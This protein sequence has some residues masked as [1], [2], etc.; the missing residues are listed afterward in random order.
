MMMSVVSM[1]HKTSSMIKLRP[2]QVEAVDALRDSLRA[3]NKRVILSAPCSMGKTHIAAFIAINAVKKNPNVKVAFFCDRLTLVGQTISAFEEINADYSVLQADDPRYDP[4]KNI[5]IVSTAT[6]IRR[7]HFRYD[8]A[9]IDEA[10]QMYKGLLDQMRQWDQVT[11]IG[12][13]ATPFSRGMGS[14]GLWQDLIVTTTPRDLIAS[15]WLC[16]ADY[17][18]GRS[19]DVSG[20]K[21]KKSNTGNS[22]Y[23]QEELGRRMDEDQTLAGDIVANYVKHSDNLTKRAVCFAPSIAY[24]KNLVRRFNEELGQEIAIH[25]DGYDSPE[26]RQMKFQ[27]FKDGVYKVMVNSQLL[28]TGWDDPAVS[29]CI[30]CKKTK[31]LTNWIQRIGRIWRIHPDKNR[32]VV[33]DHAGNLQHFKRFP[34]DVVPEELHSGSRNFDERKQTKKEEKEPILHTCPQCSGGFYGLRCKC[35]FELPI[36]SKVIKDDGTKLVKAENLS[37]AEKRRV[38]L[39]KDQKQEWYSSLLYYGYQ[40]DYKKGW[41]YHKYIEAFSCAPNGLKQVARQ[42]APEVISWITS[43]QIAWSKRR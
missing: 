1:S 40:H 9:I 18:I 24:S 19:A 8:I 41:A 42:P 25:I 32:A 37:A 36:T 7:K 11:Y 16:P 3:G 34:E 35:G 28:N 10:H 30:D 14:E 6:A 4:S 29:I 12:L 31:S 20:I 22:D 33:L 21:I 15:G 39:T 27:D 2:H 23:D 13:T 43:K 5:Q 38:T 26:I 17:Y